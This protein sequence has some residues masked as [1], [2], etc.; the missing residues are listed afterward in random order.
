MERGLDTRARRPGAEK[1]AEGARPTFTIYRASTI[2]SSAYRRH[3]K[4]I[5]SVEKAEPE[6]RRGGRGAGTKEPARLE[7]LARPQG[8]GEGLGAGE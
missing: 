6:P 4:P 8:C 3:G 7:G 5:A 1:L 2:R